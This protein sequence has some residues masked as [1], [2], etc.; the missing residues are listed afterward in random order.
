MMKG[1]GANLYTRNKNQQQQ[2]HLSRFLF[3]AV[4]V[5]FSVVLVWYWEKA[6]L[7]TTLFPSHAQLLNL[8]PGTITITII[9]PY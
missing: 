3:I 5:V 6:P 2:Q 7:V 4:V 8:F 1:G 9:K